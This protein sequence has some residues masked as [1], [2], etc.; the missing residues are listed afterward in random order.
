MFEAENSSP[1]SR[2]AAAVASYVT[3]RLAGTAPLGIVFWRDMVVIG[4]ILV[5]ASL[6]LIAVLALNDAPT[7]WI[8]FAY[9]SNWPYSFW[10]IFAVWKASGNSS[11]VQ[12][13]GARLG[14]VVWLLFAL[15]V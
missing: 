10:A 9:V 6:A 4:S 7:P 3:S 12:K 13:G 14:A 8:V 1:I 15:V 11:P 5:L 2:A